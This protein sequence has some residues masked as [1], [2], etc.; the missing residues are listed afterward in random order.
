MSLLGN[1]MKI[2]P[3]CNCGNKDNAVSC[4][5]CG[6]IINNVEVIDKFQITNDYI[7]REEKKQFRKLNAHP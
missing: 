1:K 4:V 3:K 5:D 7:G 6:E 2:C